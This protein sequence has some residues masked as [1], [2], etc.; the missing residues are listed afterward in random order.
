[1]H[2]A[3]AGELPTHFRFTVNPKTERDLGATI[4]DATLVRADEVIE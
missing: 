3:K 1:L 2:G 4:L